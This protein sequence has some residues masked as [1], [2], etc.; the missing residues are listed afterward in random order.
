[1]AVSIGI[2][3]FDSTGHRSL[4][5]I[6]AALVTVAGWTTW[7]VGTRYA[8]MLPGHVHFDPLALAMLRFGFAALV[9][10]PVWLRTGLMPKGVRLAHLIGLLGA[11]LPFAAVAVIGFQFAPASDSGPLITALLPL[12]TALASWLIL[13]ERIGRDRLA[14]L[15]MIGLGALGTLFHG[16]L[17]GVLAGQLLFVVGAVFWAGYAI[18]FRLA[19]LKAIEATAI[20]AVWS[21]LLVLPVG[22]PRLVAVAEVAPLGDL[23]AQLLIQGVVSGI[24]SILAYTIAVASLGAARATAATAITPVVIG[25]VAI[26]VLGETVTPTAA[27]FLVTTTFGVALASGAVGGPFSLTSVL[28]AG[29]RRLSRSPSRCR[30]R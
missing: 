18:A 12:I 19:G 20:V 2:T 1:M 9:F 13:S 10:S 23:A 21:A 14:G 8:V 15:A 3:R 5:G 26:P 27:L 22:L 11:G 4:Y 30:P 17:T 24:V 29:R 7:T 25:L 28:A 6:A 16:A